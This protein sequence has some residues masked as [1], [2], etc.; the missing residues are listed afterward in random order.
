M[1]QIIG[2]SRNISYAALLKQLCFNDPKFAEQ[3]AV[4]RSAESSAF[5]QAATRSLRIPD[6]HQVGRPYFTPP[7]DAPTP[8][9]A[10]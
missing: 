2:K 1:T 7:S 4:A 8:E 6:Q 9:D 3:V 10:L 5:T